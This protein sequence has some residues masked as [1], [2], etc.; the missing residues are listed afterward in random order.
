MSQKYQN[1]FKKS[2]VNKRDKRN[3]SN[4]NIVMLINKE[5]WNYV[6]KSYGL[7]ERQMQIIKLLFDGLD[8]DRIAQ[9]LRIRY[10]TVKAHFGHIY[11]RAGV[12]NKAE[13]IMQLFNIVQTYNKSKKRQ[14]E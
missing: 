4:H 2:L 9:R 8:S 3:R 10:N 12:Q 13:L 11:K 5:K 1:Q 14:K 7:T 6:R